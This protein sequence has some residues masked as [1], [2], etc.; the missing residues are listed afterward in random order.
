M[1]GKARTRA[2]NTETP[3][4]Q[5]TVPELDDLFKAARASGIATFK[6]AD[7]EFTLAPDQGRPA[8]KRPARPATEHAADL[9]LRLAGLPE[10]E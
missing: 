6:S 4:R 9:A 2:P 1:H 5:V 3:Y 8:A 7:C 10:G